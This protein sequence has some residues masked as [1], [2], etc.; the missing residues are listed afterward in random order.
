M[1]QSGSTPRKSWRRRLVAAFRFG[2]KRSDNAA[3]EAREAPG[4]SQGRQAGD[5]TQPSWA[6]VNQPTATAAPR[7]PEL[8]SWAQ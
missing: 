6:D 3:T 8:P 7:D 2:R 1:Q 4:Q 5:P